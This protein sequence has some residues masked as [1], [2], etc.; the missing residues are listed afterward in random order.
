MN[1]NQD[2]VR[3]LEVGQSSD[4]H[5]HHHRHQKQH[6]YHHHHHQDQRVQ[7]RM[8]EGGKGSEVFEVGPQSVHSLLW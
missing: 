6:Q 7:V 8:V 1:D 5:H 2:Q 4:N 3:L